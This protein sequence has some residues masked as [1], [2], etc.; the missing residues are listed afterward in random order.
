MDFGIVLKK[1]LVNIFINVVVDLGINMFIILIVR[2]TYY[3]LKKLL[4]YY[5]INVV[6][7]L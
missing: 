4:V 1:A 5:L 3:L 2:I 6:V 7:D